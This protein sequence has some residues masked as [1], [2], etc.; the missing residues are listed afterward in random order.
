[1]ADEREDFRLW[2]EYLKLSDDYQKLCEWIRDDENFK[3]DW[4]MPGANY[5]TLSPLADLALIPKAQYYRVKKLF[6]SVSQHFIDDQTGRWRTFDDSTVNGWN[7]RLLVTYQTFGDVHTNN[8]E[9]WWGRAEERLRRFQEH[10]FKGKMHIIGKLTAM[11]RKELARDCAN[12][13]FT[14]KRLRRGELQD[15]LDVFRLHE[16]NGFTWREIAA[17]FE[18][19]FDEHEQRKMQDKRDKAKRIIQNAERGVFPGDYQKQGG[20]K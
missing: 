11:Q 19:S 2:W 10:E 3:F 8:F 20:D 9:E 5:S 1:M 16:L 13:C 4:D 12:P 18:R 15:Y 6:V 14:A 7:P 17:E